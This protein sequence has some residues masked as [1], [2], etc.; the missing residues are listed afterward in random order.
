MCKFCGA[1]VWAAEFTGTHM[2]TGPKAYSICCAKGKVQLPLLKE[3]PPELKQLLTGTTMREIKFQHNLRMYNIIFA[4][5]SFGGSV[6]ESINNGSGPYV[7]RVNDH[8]YHSNG[9][10]VPP[11]GRTPKFAQ[12]Y[13]YDGQ[14]AVDY[15][16]QFPLS[17]DQLDPDI[18]NLLLQMLNRE[19]ALLGIFKQI[20]ERYPLSEQIPVRLRLL[21]RR[22]ADGRFVNR[23]S[24]N[25]YEFVGLAVDKNLANHRD[26]VVEY[27]RGGLQRITEIH[28]CFMSLQYPLLFTRGEDGY[29]L[30]IKHRNVNNANQDNDMTVSM[31]EFQAF[32][33]QCRAS[34]GHTLL[35]GGDYF[36]NMWLMSGVA[37]NGRLKW[38]EKHQ[39][40]IRSNL[41]KNIVDSVRHGDV[42]AT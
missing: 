10:L 14:E 16:L 37:L 22:S 19:N 21:E 18:V 25:D 15:R 35:L 11:D 27:K 3:T 12:F 34:E 38:V 23:I 6:D 7:F 4:L 9:S 20:R 5:C 30:G 40:I 17:R 26:I 42:S 8:V 13:M 1:L 2:G 31:R 33:L 29:R 24:R 39:S 32:R 41:Y 36:Y 28:P